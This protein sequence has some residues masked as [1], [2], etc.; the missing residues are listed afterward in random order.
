MNILIDELPEGIEIDGSFYGIR[1]DFRIWI[2][3]ELLMQD[4]LLSDS[5]KAAAALKLCYKEVPKNFKA[6]I[7]GILWF[8]SC[9]KPPKAKTSNAEDGSSVK[10]IYCFE[11]DD[12]YIYAAFLSQYGI[13][14]QD[15]DL[16]WWKFKALFKALGEDNQIVKIMGYR[17]MTIDGRMSDEQKRYYLQMKE[18]YALEDGRSEEEKQRGFEQD[19]LGGL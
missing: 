16:H 10:A 13:D 18:L 4:R 17:A 3:F 12:D 9:S 2:M 8:Y 1:H 6:A 15:A 14:L 7:D 19:L 5:E 11:Q